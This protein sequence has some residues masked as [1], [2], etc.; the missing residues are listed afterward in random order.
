[1]KPIIC[2][3]FRGIL[4]GAAMLSAGAG[5]AQT[6]P[7]HPVR[8]I[9]PF[10]PGGPTDVMARILAQKL[11]ESLGQ[12]FVVE[13]RAGAGGNIGMNLAAKAAPDGYTILFA[14]SSYVV[15]PSLYAKAGYD[16]YKDFAPVTV[17]AASPNVLVV[18][19][20]VAAKNVQEL[21][22]LVRANAGKFNYA[23]PGT[24]T[25]P[26]L[27]GEL[28]RLAFKLDLVNVP[29]NG[30]G[31]AVTATL[32][33]QTP[34]A[35]VAVPP[36]MPHV[37][38]GALRALAVT[39][40]RRTASLPDVPTMGESGAAGQEAETMQGVLFPAAIPREIVE[41][42]HREIVRAVALPEVKERLSA[43][44]FDPV[45]NTPEEFAAYIRAEVDK[46][47]KVIREANIKI[48]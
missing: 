42:L 43:L 38:S 27:S 28:F 34:V 21:V 18:H 15:N 30:A 35:F 48:E 14:S 7:T 9:V 12:Q 37:R 4:C 10:A 6:W 19:P 25:T 20:S 46:W 41:R 8:I 40:A 5:V 23:Q 45:A 29:F 11:S 36:A 13:N 17:A 47:A 16:P 22:A 1:M 2:I 3:F 33:N 31:P 39:S 26:H 44:G 32:G 24:G